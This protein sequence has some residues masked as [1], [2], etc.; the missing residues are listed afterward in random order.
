ME[1]ALL[2]A[3]CI[4]PPIRLP[5]SLAPETYKPPCTADGKI[6]DISYWP[7]LR[8]ELLH[9]VLYARLTSVAGKAWPGASGDAV[10]GLPMAD[11]NIVMISLADPATFH[12]VFDEETPTQV[13]A[14]LYKRRGIKSPQQASEDMLAEQAAAWDR[15]QRKLTS[16][17]EPPTRKQDFSLKK[18]LFLER[19][20]GGLETAISGRKGL[21]E[22]EWIDVL[23]TALPELTELELQMHIA[24]RASAAKMEAAKFCFLVDLS[25][26]H[27]QMRT[28]AVHAC[29]A[30]SGMG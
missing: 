9:A 13:V 16:V 6:E 10:N 26:L 19:A 4:V 23:R 28:R 22:L 2:A 15:A 3:I 27:P 24:S 14:R 7:F 12:D 29:R 18:N 1:A 17:V 25:C 8:R 5:R 30:G 21:T 20:N 11:V